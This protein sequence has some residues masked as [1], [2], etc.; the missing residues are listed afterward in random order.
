MTDGA[1][2][3]QRSAVARRVFDLACALAGLVVTGPIWPVIA[4]AIRIDS[5]GPILYRAVRVGRGGR[6][7]VVHK[8]RTMVADP[9]AAGP[10]VTAAGD[11]RITRV[12]RL[13][14]R[15]KLDELPQLVDVARGTMSVV[16]PRPEDPRYV[17]R[18]SA[19]Q[20]A[21]L[22]HRPGLLS[23]AT[24]AFRDEESVLAA[25]GA[26][27]AAYVELVLG[28]KLALDLDYFDRRSLRRD[29]RVLVA[30]LVAIARP[31]RAAA[32]SAQLR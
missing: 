23:P 18:Y 29:L 6:P 3:G 32:L 5:P 22:A 7:I 31:R 24:I 4:A 1:G 27:E 30:G 12:G 15:S 21:L 17:E 26:T 10:A 13:L 28:Q 8:F 9:A 11:P 25:A 14:R 2:A 19:E 16:G 20:R